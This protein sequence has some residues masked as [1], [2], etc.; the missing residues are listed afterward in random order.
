MERDNIREQLIDLG[1]WDADDARDP[2]KSEDVAREL[3]T[4]CEERFRCELRES[5]SQDGS[6]RHYWI[7]LAPQYDQ[8]AHE[9]SYAAAMCRAAIELHSRLGS[10][11]DMG[12]GDGSRGFRSEEG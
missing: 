1:L 9:H 10:S 12:M 3:K 7:K 2:S 8:L 11:V 4:R 5:S 6:E